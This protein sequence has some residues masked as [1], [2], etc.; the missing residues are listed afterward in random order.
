VIE[1]PVVQLFFETVPHYGIII[2]V[3]H[4]LL[5]PLAVGLARLRV[6]NPHILRLFSV[7]EA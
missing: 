6:A 3:S 5:Y 1:L 7:P 4:A 2:Q